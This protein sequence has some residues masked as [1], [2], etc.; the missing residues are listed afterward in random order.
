MLIF[1][2][3]FGH[4]IIYNGRVKNVG[5][6]FDKLFALLA[7]RQISIYHLKRDKVIGTATIDKLRK[8]EGNI[9]TRSINSICKYLHCQ[10]GDIMEYVDD[11]K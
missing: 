8:R 9:D 7:E 4:T 11:E 6:V 1:D 10:P 2:L 3:L 5:I